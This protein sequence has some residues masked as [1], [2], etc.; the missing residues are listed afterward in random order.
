MKNFFKNISLKKLSNKLNLIFLDKKFIFDIKIEYIGY[1]YHFS[2][3]YKIVNIENVFIKHKSNKNN[4][5]SI[6]ESPHYKFL[7]G[8]QESYKKYY[9]KNFPGVNLDKQLERF[10]YLNENINFDELYIFTQIDNKYEN[11]FLIV[12]GAHRASIAKKKGI[13]KIKCYV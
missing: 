8:N 10:E 6:S 1:R 4:I 5:L 9:L 7:E 11:R 3:G 13:K 12:D 2:I